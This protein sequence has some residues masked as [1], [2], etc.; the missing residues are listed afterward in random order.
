VFQVVSTYQQQE[1][2]IYL[3]EL[4]RITKAVVEECASS[5][6]GALRRFRDKYHGS[7]HH[8]EGSGSKLYD[9]YK[10]LEWAFRE[11]EQLQGLREKL[12][13]NTERLSLLAGLAA[14]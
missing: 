10:K 6:E 14:R 2:S 12:Q 8:A 7:L 4:D 11:K 9:G 3:S 1:N 5:I 13:R